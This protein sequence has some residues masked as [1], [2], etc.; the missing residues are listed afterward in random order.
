M[1]PDFLEKMVAA[2]DAHRDCEVAHAP[3]V[4]VD[5]NGPVSN[6]VW[7]DTTVFAE[8]MRELMKVRHIRRAPYDGLLQLSGQHTVLSITQLL[9][10]RSIFSRVGYF[11]NRWG[12]IS[13][14]NWEMKA[15]L[16]ANTIHVPDTWA[17]WRLHSSQATARQDFSS[18][19]YHKKVDDMIEDAVLSC[20][21]Y[22]PPLIKEAL[23]SDLIPTAREMRKYYRSLRDRESVIRRRLFQLSEMCFGLTTARNEILGQ[24]LGKPKWID[25][26]PTAMSLWL[27]SLG[28][29]PISY[30]SIGSGEKCEEYSKI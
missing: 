14:F 5:E 2:L 28:V 27:E 10:R 4:I 12:S 30:C 16:V 1:A 8:G 21:A 7:P 3:L 26:V 15:G 20:E 17:T 11:P 6:R 19:A 25:N 29:Q 24:L 22:L 18:P 13:D 9:I 23:K